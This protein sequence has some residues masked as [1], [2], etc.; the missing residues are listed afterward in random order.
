MDMATVYATI[1]NGGRLV[2]PSGIKQV[3][4]NEGRENEKVLREEGDRP[5]GAQ[6][7]DPEIARA[8]TEVMIGDVTQGIA[9]KANLGERPVAG[10][11]GTSENFFD[12]WFVGFTPKLVTG[13]WM[14]YAEG[15]ATLEGLLALESR[16]QQGPIAPPAVIFQAHMQNV[17]AGEPVE[18][19]EGIEGPQTTT[20]E[21]KRVP[22]GSPSPEG[23]VPQWNQ[24]ASDGQQPAPVGAIP[25][26]NGAAAVPS[27][28]PGQFS[29]TPAA[30]VTSPPSDG[31][32]ASQY[33]F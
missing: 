6:V 19:F 17:L 15:G 18:R 10:K 25:G 31:A 2:S 14:G 3:V 22:G 13:V 30:P 4:Q 1:A 20:D 28:P 24:P 11:S 26:A 21:A 9:T 27:M 29:E 5:E 8:A 16:T 12:S 7:I 33:G 23:T 32:A